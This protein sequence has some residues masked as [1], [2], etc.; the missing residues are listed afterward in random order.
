LNYWLECF[1]EPS[2]GVAKVISDHIYIL[3]TKLDE[4]DP[5]DFN[6]VCEEC[7]NVS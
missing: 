5:D 4:D 2:S 3:L 1:N 6:E 7:V